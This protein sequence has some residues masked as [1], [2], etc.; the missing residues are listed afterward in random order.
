M[1]IFFSHRPN[2]FF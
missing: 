2:F 1:P